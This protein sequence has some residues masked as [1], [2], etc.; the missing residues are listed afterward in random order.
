MT[1]YAY[2]A[3]DTRGRMKK[4]IQEADS[5]RV[6]RQK[7]RS[8]G[9]SPVEVAPAEV[10]RQKTERKIQFLTR[11]A[12][13]AEVSM[14]TRQ[15]ATLVAA[16]IPIEEALQA[17]SKQVGKSHLRMIVS[18]VRA[19][20]LEGRTLADAMACYPS[21]FDGLYRAMV[22]AGEKSGHLDVILE[23]L[24]D[25][26]EQRQKIRSKLIQALIYPVIL[27]LVAVGVVTALLTTVVPT[28]I[29]QFQYA[30]RDLPNITLALI[31]A[32]DF[33]RAYG[34]VVLATILGLIVIRQRLM[35][36]PKRRLQNDRLLLKLPVAGKVISGVET[37]RFARTLSIL[38]SSGVPLVESMAISTEV[39]G[40]SYIREKLREAS[41]RVR[42]GS[43][44]W[45]S[46]DAT[47]LFPPMM[48]HIIASGERS[49]E[50]D[51]ML[52]RA[53]SAQDQL[54]EDQVNI[55]LGIFGP[56]M[57]VIMAG[58]VLFIVMAILT[59]MTDMSSLLDM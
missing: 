43:S 30:G 17:L 32:S 14:M 56:L 15:L 6:L 57:I 26:T 38:T 11:R 20:V 40:N 1:L 59:P 50:L 16:A 25:Y 29:E 51:N 45:T 37:A 10:K 12:S 55:A 22:A 36:F 54:F 24:A 47:G 9:L 8:E 33:L 18:T 53:A 46:L 13:S 39:L 41:D 4:G 42:E 5:P 34:L 2:S 35:R 19:R 7:L 27:T 44:L 48:L 58:M 21:V 49:G 3:L 31:A 28:V 23:R 52:E